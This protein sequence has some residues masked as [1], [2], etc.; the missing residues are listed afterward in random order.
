[1]TNKNQN[2]KATLEFE[3]DYTT[4]EDFQSLFDS[5]QENQVKEGTITRGE[6]IAVENDIVVIDIGAKNEGYVSIKEFFA[7]NE[8]PKVGDL[9]DVYLE[10]IESRNGNTII[11]RDKA[12][13]EEY[14]VVLEKALNNSTEVTGTIFGKVKGG[15]TV[16]VNGII[17]FLPGSQVDVRP[18]K[19]IT[20]LMGIAQP[21]KIL[22]IDRKQGNVVV[23]RRAIL[24][25]SRDENREEALSSIKEGLV[26]DGV[27]KNITDYGAFIDLGSVDGLLHVTDI[28]WGRINHPSEILTL[29]QTVQVMITKFNEETK[30]ISL[31]MK[32]LEDNPWKGIESRYPK[33]TE[34][35]GKVTNITDYGVFVALE[36]GIEGL[37]HVSEIAWGKNN[38]HP[39]KLVNPNQEVKFVVL[40]IDAAK[41]R[42]SLGMKQCND[43]PWSKFE[44]TYPAGSVVEGYVKNVVDF[45]LFVGF[46]NEIDGLVHISDLTWNEQESVEALK[47]Y[48][49]DQAVTVK[50]LS[51]ESDKERISLGI[52][53]LTDNNFSKSVED[54]DVKKGKV[55]T[56]VVKTI[57][58]DGLEV[59]VAGSELVGFIKLNDLSSEKSEQKVERFAVGEKIDAKI[60]AISNA[61]Q[62]IALSIRSLEIEEKKKAIKEY[63]STDSGASLGDIL[64]DALTSVESNKKD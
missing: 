8:D 11:S 32:Q 38:I 13:K 33:G 16:D 56:C 41:H 36:P 28:S 42:I 18:V 58:E 48:T 27:V 40:D 10:K 20:P 62:S 17:A 1:M 52:K 5:A 59:E 61:T 30:R 4:S 7:N 3:H 51:I 24:E 44:D 34:F 54:T 47:S 46:N 19:N 29:G 64:G 23:S 2:N 9:F 43:N 35:V 50:I 25:V 60:V 55:V 26:L 37:V 49:K 6:V 15:F 63:G 14:W 12:L 39:K 53:Q 45:G 57:K 21:F 22:K 31:G